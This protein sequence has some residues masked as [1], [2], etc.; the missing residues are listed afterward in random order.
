MNKI[1]R[2]VLSNSILCSCITVG[3]GTKRAI[4]KDEHYPSLAFGSWVA[5]QRATDKTI[6]KDF[7]YAFEMNDGNIVPILD[8]QLN[9]GI[10]NISLSRTNLKKYDIKTS[11]LLTILCIIRKGYCV[12]KYTDN[13]DGIVKYI[14]ITNNMYNRYKQHQSDKLKEHNW[15]IEFIDGLSKTD[16]EILESHFISHYKTYKFYNKAKSTD[17]I[18]Q[19]LM[20]PETEWR[21]YYPSNKYHI[22]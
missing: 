10:Y 22:I 16:A 17:G 18:S 4:Y 21:Y 15:T 8:F 9:E 3:K 14:G 12:Y 13:A 5:F 20:I 19:Y 1:E 6:N 2:D 7:S 11:K